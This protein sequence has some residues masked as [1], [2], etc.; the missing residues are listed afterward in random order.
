MIRAKKNLKFLAENWFWVHSRQCYNITPSIEVFFFQKKVTR[1]QNVFVRPS[2]YPSVRPTNKKFKTFWNGPRCTRKQ[3]LTKNQTNLIR[4]SYLMLFTYPF[5]ALWKLIRSQM[6]FIDS[7]FCRFLLKS[8]NLPRISWNIWKNVSW[9]RHIER[10]NS[11][12]TPFIKKYVCA[13]TKPK[14]ISPMYPSAVV[15]FHGKLLENIAK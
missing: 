9:C 1:G 11:K 10:K 13:A 2:I 14:I 3:F 5:A 12:I 8:S 6:A 15:R 7:I 4:M